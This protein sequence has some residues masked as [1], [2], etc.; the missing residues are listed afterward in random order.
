MNEPLNLS[1][2][3][4]KLDRHQE[5]KQIFHECWRQMR[6]FFY[7]PDMHGVDWKAMRRSYERPGAP[8]QPPRRLDLHHRR[9]DRRAE[10]R[11]TLMS[12][13][14]ICRK[15]PRIPTGLLGAE[16]KRD[17]ATGITGSTKILQGAGLGPKLRSPLTEIGVDVKEGDYIIAVNGQPTNEMV[18]I[19]EALVG[20]AGK[21]V[22]LKVNAEPTEK[23]SREM[24][25]TPI[26]DEA[27]LYYYNWVAGQH[28]EGQRRHRRQGRLHPRSRHA[29]H[30]A[31]RVRQALLSAG[32]QESPDHRR[33]RQ[34]RRQ[35]LAHADR[36]P[37]AARS[38]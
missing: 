19:Y 9:D 34:R 33:A 8:R 6:D 30:R 22:T 4:M 20:T 32:A 29:G 5:W 31:Q 17:P 1:G 2:M 16:L 15:P 36:A 24:V 38:T 11:A 35:R 25:V 12:A 3:E 27:E 23:G 7:D 21:Q 26:A 10:Q 13:A 37:A 18:N 14:A 28:Q